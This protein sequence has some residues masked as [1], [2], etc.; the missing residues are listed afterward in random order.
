MN[1]RDLYNKINYIGMQKRIRELAIREKL[2]S[3]DE[4]ATITDVEACEL[5]TQN[6]ELIFSEGER[7]GLVHKDNVNKLYNLIEIISR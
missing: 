2:A 6:Y 3:A 5:I 1:E 7:I 4:L